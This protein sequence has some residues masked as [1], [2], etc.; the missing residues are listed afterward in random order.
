MRAIVRRGI[1]KCCPGCSCNIQHSGPTI[2]KFDP[3][4]TLT[5]C[6]CASKWHSSRHGR[7]VHMLTQRTALLLHQTKLKRMTSKLGRF[8]KS[9]RRARRRR[10]LL[11]SGVVPFSL[12]V[13]RIRCV[14]PTPPS[15]TVPHYRHVITGARSKMADCASHFHSNR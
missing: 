7:S 9:T 15:D 14:L 10:V 4:I 11:V 6:Y 13:S 3:V 5:H 8:L 1:R 2:G 12:R